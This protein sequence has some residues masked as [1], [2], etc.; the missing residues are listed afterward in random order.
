M[1]MM[2]TYEYKKKRRKL[3]DMPNPAALTA[4]SADV[5]RSFPEAS[6][7]VATSALL[8]QVSPSILLLRCQN[9]KEQLTA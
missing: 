9:W 3:Q 5:N 6:E 1:E 8:E 7:P 2:S 4:R